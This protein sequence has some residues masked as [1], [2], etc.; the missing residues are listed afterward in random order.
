MIVKSFDRTRKEKAELERLIVKAARTDVST[1]F[2]YALQMKNQPVH[3]LWN[4]II[5]D[6]ARR[7]ISYDAPVEHGKSTQILIGRPLFQLGRNP[8]ELMALVS[9]SPDLP[10]RALKVIRQH[11]ETNERVHRVFPKLKLVESTNQ[12]ITVERPRSNVKDASAVGIGIE[13]NILGKRWTYLITDDVL[14]FSTTW[15][16]ASREKIW[17][18]I[19]RELLGRLVAKSKHIDIGTP[20]VGTDPR[21]KLRRMPG[22]F[23][24]R[25]DGW[26]GSVYD[27]NGK[28]V[29]KFEGG[30]WPELVT[31]PVTGIEYGWPRWRLEE[32]RRQMPSHEF[33]R[34]IRCRALTA[35]AQFLSEHLDF[36]LRLGQGIR[37]QEETAS[38]GSVRVAW[39]R[40]EAGWRNI[41]TGVD[42]AIT[43]EDHAA[44]T[45]F[46]TGAVEERKKHILELR[47][48]KVEG[49]DILRNMIAILRRYPLHSGQFRVE[50]NQGQ[51]FLAQFAEEPG[52]LEAL[53]ATP[54]EADRV[55]IF[56]HTTHSNKSAE[57]IGIRAMNMEFE[58]RRWPIPC[59]P[60]MEITPLVQEW[61]DAL[62]NFDPLNHPDDMVIASWLFWEQSRETDYFGDSSWAK[63]G[64]FVPS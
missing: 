34:Q 14:R 42:L 32:L 8:F 25:F 50:T 6:P 19:L 53:G 63:F 55:K 37:L 10:R 9:S 28:F 12:W 58:R 39:R 52:M 60:E 21:H 31:D 46:F 57:G 40:P 36:C 5:D 64:I 2:H 44:D 17:A 16:E 49:P 11:I 61:V 27:V 62:K 54:E 26:D 38:N 41:M 22:Y 48:G 23:F 20:W 47:K 3:R 30:L 13:G 7:R 45:A 43:K 1:F 56:P 33:D 4:K 15:T 51:R 18:R 24:L 35:A 59:G 29:R